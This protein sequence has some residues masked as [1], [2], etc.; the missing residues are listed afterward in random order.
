MIFRR[1]LLPFSW[2]YWIVTQHRNKMFD[3]GKKPSTSFDVPIIS[4]GNIT[5][6][7]TGKTPLTEYII[8]QLSEF[9]PI[10]LL[11]RGY[12]RKTNGVIIADDNS[13][14]QQIGDEPMQMKLKFPNLMVCVAEKRVDGANALLNS[15]NP[16]KII[17]LDDAFQHR[18]IKPG[19]SI[20]VTD[21]HRPMWRDLVFPAGNLRESRKGISR[22]DAVMVSKC[23]K[24][25]SIKEAEYIKE[26]LK[27][28][29]SQKLFF[30]TIEYEKPRP[31]KGENRFF[32]DELS[33]FEN[34]LTAVAGIGNPKPFFTKAKDFSKSANTVKFKDHHNFTESDIEKIRT[35]SIDERG[36]K[37]LILTTEK[38]AVRLSSLPFLDD[39]L[40]ERI[41]YIPIS[42]KIMFDKEDEFNFMIKDYI[43]EK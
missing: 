7:G 24:N 28:S 13:T 1:L 39:D 10:A 37:S 4:I 26:K 12:G 38:D 43:T 9:S 15:P 18:H 22:A 8:S 34:R 25:L 35:S 23:P 17:L 11:S 31:I 19:F 16:P 21:Y 6:G 40:A 36:N 27:I 3:S 33:K 5:V 41:W 32:S 30:S 42:P 14:Y 2:I 20:L 29:S